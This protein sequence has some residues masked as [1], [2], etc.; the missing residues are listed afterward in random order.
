[1]F[2]RPHTS[3]RR[4]PIPHSKSIVQAD[5]PHY[6]QWSRASGLYLSPLPFD[7]GTENA[8]A[9]FMHTV[10]GLAFRR[11]SGTN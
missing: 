9:L 6:F 11:P 10:L 5:P 3:H 4:G 1:M 7:P 8:H 2:K